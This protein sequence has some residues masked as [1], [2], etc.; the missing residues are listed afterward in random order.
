MDPLWD[1]SIIVELDL[2]KVLYPIQKRCF[3]PIFFG[4]EEIFTILWQ[5]LD[6]Y[7]QRQIVSYRLIL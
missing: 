5:I 3:L 4:L 1:L 7:Y 2:I 6:Q